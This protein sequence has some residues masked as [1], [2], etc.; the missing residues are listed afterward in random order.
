M[1]KI[2]IREN[3]NEDVGH[4]VWSVERVDGQMLSPK[5]A[6]QSLNYHDPETAEIGR[7]RIE[8]EINSGDLKI[9]AKYQ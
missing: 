6:I 9:T 4:L 1:I 5:H 8:R 3:F 2:Q 7:D